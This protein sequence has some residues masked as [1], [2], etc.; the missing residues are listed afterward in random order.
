VIE[1]LRHGSSKWKRLQRVKTRSSQGF[2][3][4]HVSIRHGGLVRLGW[5]SL[6]HTWYYSRSMTVR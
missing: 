4:T 1:F 2:V 5:E 6:T 3:F